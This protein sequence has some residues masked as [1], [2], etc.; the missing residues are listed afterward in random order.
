MISRSPNGM[1]VE[2]AGAPTCG[3]TGTEI[4]GGCE[5]S[6]TKIPVGEIAGPPEGSVA[7]EDSAGPEEIA[8]TVG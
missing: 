6:G 3:A 8:G 1:E 2:P 7:P 4:G 5:T